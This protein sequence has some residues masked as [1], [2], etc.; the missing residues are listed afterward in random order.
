MDIYPSDLAYCAF[1]SDQ[2]FSKNNNAPA[3]SQAG[4]YGFYC[5]ARASRKIS[6]YICNLG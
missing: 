4:F 1:N 6:K 5:A 3:S 2:E